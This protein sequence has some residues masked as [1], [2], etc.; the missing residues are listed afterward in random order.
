[1]M[2]TNLRGFLDHGVVVYLDDIIIFSKTREEHEVLVK[3]LLARLECHDLVVSLKKSVFHVDTVAL[4][5]YIVGKGSVTLSEKKVASIL[6]WKAP[7]SVKVVQILIG[8]A[9]FYRCFIENFS[10]VCQ[11]ITD[12]LKTKGGKHLWF[13]GEEQN[14]AFEDRKRRFT[15]TRI[16]APFYPV[17]KTVIE[18]D[19]T[20]FALGY[21]LFGYFGNRLHPLAFHSRKL[22]DDKLNYEIPDK[23]LL[24]M[25]EAFS[26]WK[27]DMLGA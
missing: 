20:D 17:R 11:Q 19:A 21:I 5:G 8:F 13:W 2:N 23:E 7:Q 12:T 3:Q 16:R 25:L 1:M 14:A 6:N 10:K 24:A 9:N 4:L 27:H 26:E 15:S 18:T 22:N